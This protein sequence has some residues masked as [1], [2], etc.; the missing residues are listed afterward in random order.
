MQEN[1]MPLL[2]VENMVKQFPVKQTLF[3]IAARRK[4]K[5]VRAVDNVSLDVMHGE[6]VGL[7]GESGCGKSTLAKTIDHL[8]TPDGGKMLFNGEDVFSLDKNAQRRARFKMQMVFQDPYSSLNPRMTVRQMFYEVQ[9]VHKLCPRRN[10]EK[11][12]LHILDLVGMDKNALDRY[13]SQFSGGQ[14]QRISIARALIMKPELL[15]AD[16]PV[17]ALDVSIQAQVIN[18]L[19]ELKDTLNLTMLFISHDLRVIRYISDRVIV[20]YLGKI[21][22]M[23]ETE[24]LFDHPHHPYTDILMKSAPAVDPDSEGRDYTI[25]G[26]TPSPLNIPSGCRFHPRCPY[27]QDICRREEPQLKDIGNGRCAACHFILNQ[28]AEK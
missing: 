25:Q 15:I 21:V 10:R 1:R 8:Y 7:V 19:I 26:E 24:D 14:R 23:G 28:H 20:M 6:T 13:P 16:E 11:E 17:S 4:V 9:S 3:E 2:H 18:L 12:C 27:A 5:Y 22:E